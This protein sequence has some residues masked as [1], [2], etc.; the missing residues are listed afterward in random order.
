VLLMTT[1]PFVALGLLAYPSAAIWAWASQ[2][3]GAW[4]AAMLGARVVLAYQ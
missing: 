2:G 1:L 4:L 3:F